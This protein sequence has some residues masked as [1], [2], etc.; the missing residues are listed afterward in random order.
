MINLNIP[1]SKFLNPGDILMCVANGSI[2]LVGKTVII[3][4]PG[5]AF[6]SF[7][8][9]I[10]SKFNQYLNFYFQSPLFKKDD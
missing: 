10:V 3:N 6:G 7:M 5:F 8:V 1:E 9:K 4:Q 2:N